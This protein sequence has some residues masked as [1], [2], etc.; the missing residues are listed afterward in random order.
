MD[1]DKIKD[2]R[3]N[4]IEKLSEEYL[5]HTIR[6]GY[7]LRNLGNGTINRHIKTELWSKLRDILDNIEKKY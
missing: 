6:F 2:S 5:L 3:D 1:E 7:A 4:S